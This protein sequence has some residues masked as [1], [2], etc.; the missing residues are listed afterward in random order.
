MGAENFW[1]ALI[2]EIPV[3]Y[4]GEV[5]EVE[6]VDFLLG[7]WVFFGFFVLGCEDQ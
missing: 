3:V 5:F 7:G 1:G 2:D 4:G 6:G